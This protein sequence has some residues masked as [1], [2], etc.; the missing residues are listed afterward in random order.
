MVT[1]EQLE[2]LPHICLID[3]GKQCGI[4]DAIL[5]GKKQLISLL[6]K[7]KDQDKLEQIYQ[8]HIEMD[9]M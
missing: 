1:K 4:K 2:K 8:H 3:F 6:L 9:N 5:K 7:Y